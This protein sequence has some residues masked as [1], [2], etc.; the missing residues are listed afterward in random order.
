MYRHLLAD[1][2]LNVFIL[3]P[4]HLEMRQELNRGSVAPVVYHLVV[5]IDRGL[6]TCDALKLASGVS[7]VL[8][9]L[10]QEPFNLLFK[11][12]VVEFEAKIRCKLYHLLQSLL[13][14]YSFSIEIFGEAQKLIRKRQ[15]TLL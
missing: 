5:V 4:D 1:L 11:L 9:L 13:V 2:R 14:R 3:S 15:L 7:D 6:Q 12:L 10:Y 8:L